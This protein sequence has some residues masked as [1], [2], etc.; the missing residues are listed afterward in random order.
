MSVQ[1]ALSKLKEA[2]ANLAAEL[3]AMD[4]LI[5]DAETPTEK[6]P[7]VPLP[8]VQD[9]PPHLADLQPP[10]PAPSRGDFGA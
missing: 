6:K 10:T 2:R 4:A 9:L 8:P 3:A 5:G 7:V 1:D